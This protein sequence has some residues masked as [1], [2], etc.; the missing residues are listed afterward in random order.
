M[1]RAKDTIWRPMIPA[2][3]KTHKITGRDGDLVE[4]GKK[5]RKGSHAYGNWNLLYL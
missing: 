3:A 5:K 1:R 4:G 2:T